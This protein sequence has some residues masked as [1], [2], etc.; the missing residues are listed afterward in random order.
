[1][2]LMI[3]TFLLKKIKLKS[4]KKDQESNDIRMNLV[5]WKIYKEVQGLPWHVKL[6]KRRATCIT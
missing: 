2:M 5:L 6:E 1:M 4:Q 3:L